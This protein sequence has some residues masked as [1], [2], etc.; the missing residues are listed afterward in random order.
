MKVLWPGFEMRPATLH[1]NPT[2]KDIEIMHEL[3]PLHGW[4]GGWH[5][6]T[7]K[8]GSRQ[9]VGRFQGTDISLTKGHDLA[10]ASPVVIFSADDY[11]STW[12]TTFPVTR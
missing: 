10:A 7:G 11:R 4:S 2:P 12:N 1:S 6:V 9:D 8:H 5:D 3:S